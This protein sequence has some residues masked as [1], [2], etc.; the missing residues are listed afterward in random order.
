M[1]K[2]KTPNNLSPLHTVAWMICH[3]SNA[4]WNHDPGDIWFFWSRKKNS[5]FNLICVTSLKT[6]HAI[7]AFVYSQNHS[8]LLL[9]QFK[10]QFKRPFICYKNIWILSCISSNPSAT[11]QNVFL[12]GNMAALFFLTSH[13]DTE[14][15]K[16]CIYLCSEQ[17]ILARTT[18]FII[19]G[20]TRLYQNKITSLNKICQK[21]AFSVIHWKW[22]QASVHKGDQWGVGT[23]SCC[24]RVTKEN[25]HLLYASGGLNEGVSALP[26]YEIAII[27]D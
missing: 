12:H 8:C 22:C 18:G 14:T 11:S 17:N 16:G 5:G 26:K 6:Q 10:R 20:R 9:R 24:C 7:A 27:G 15:V 23:T 13:I 3:R 1:H 4:W 19:A 25:I 21:A 2:Q